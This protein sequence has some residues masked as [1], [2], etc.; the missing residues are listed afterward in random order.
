MKPKIALFHPWIKSRG[1]AERTILEILKN[2]N[3]EL[4]TWIYEKDKTFREFEKYK[5]NI[6]APKI[7]KK[8]SRK[9]VLR[10]L[11][12]LISLFSKIPLKKYDY[13][14]ISTSGVGEFITFRNYLPKRTYAYVHTPLRAANNEI[15]KWNLKNRYKNPFS[16][17]IYLSAVKIYKFFEKIAWKKIDFAIF[18]SELSLKRAKKLIKNNKKTS[19]IYPPIKSK[20]FEK[21]KCKKGGYFLY[22]SRF[23]FDKRQDVFL[24]AWKEFEKNNPNEKLILTGTIENKKY[25]EKIKKIYGKC[26]NVEIKTNV[27]FKELLTLYKNSKALIYIP[28]LEDFGII[29]FEALALGKPL[30]A[31]DKGGY[32]KLVKDFSQ[33]VLIKEKYSKEDMKKEIIKTLEKFNKSKIKSKKIVIKKITSDRFIKN[34]GHIFK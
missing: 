6:I 28:F 22:P 8:F 9:Y 34:I 13:F 23:S 25:F 2:T 14:L 27:K 11:F 3:S 24:R 31:V 12:L 19:V 4:W 17:L 26:K 7:A 1:G 16:K 5:I 15:I 32:V 21:L 29:P 30:I 10:G 33:V 20:E 18:N